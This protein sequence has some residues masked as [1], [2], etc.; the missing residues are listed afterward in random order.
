MFS[1]LSASSVP[2]PLHDR[3][4]EERRLSV[5]QKEDDS[6]HPGELDWQMTAGFRTLPGTRALPNSFPSFPSKSVLLYEI[7][8]PNMVA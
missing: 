8:W 2:L 1:D 3:S 6:V 4:R 7:C 5:D